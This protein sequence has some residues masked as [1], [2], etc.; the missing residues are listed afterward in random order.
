MRFCL[1]C[2]AAESLQLKLL[3]MIVR[4]QGQSNL[5]SICS[6]SIKHILERILAKVAAGWNWISKMYSISIG[7]LYTVWYTVYYRICGICGV[8]T[9]TAPA[10]L[11]NKVGGCGSLSLPHCTIVQYKSSNHTSCRFLTP[12][13]RL[14]RNTHTH[15]RTHTYHGIVSKRRHLKNDCHRPNSSF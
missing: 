1:R 15:T 3:Q 5:Q 13:P 6:N 8:Q 7:I 14:K 11:E 10:P 12:S 2:V 9:L 4:H